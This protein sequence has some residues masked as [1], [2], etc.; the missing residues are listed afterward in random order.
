LYF[1]GVYNRSEFFINGSSLG[2]RPNGYV[3]FMYDATPY[4]EYGKNNVIAVRVDHSQYAD[5]RWYTGSGIYR[6]VWLVTASPTHISQWGVSVSGGNKPGYLA[7]AVE[8][9]NE[10]NAT[11]NLTIVNE[12]VKDDKT[13]AKDAKKL[14]IPAS[15][16]AKLITDL[17]V[18]NPLLWDLE[19]PNLYSLKTS[20]Y[21]NGEL[22]DETTTVTGFRSFNFDPD[23][24]FSLND[25]Q[26]KVKGVC[27]HHDAGV[28]GAA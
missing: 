26:I 28:L 12:L 13:I 19:T 18:K 25:K 14:N 3:S 1:E 20:V 7:I 22:I 2:K 21:K 9:D 11:A 8:V 16:K 10:L 15:T 27:I 6:N 24:G 17:K 5:S 4:I 23:K